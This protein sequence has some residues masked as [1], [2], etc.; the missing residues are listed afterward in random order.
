MKRSVSWSEIQTLDCTAKHAFRYT[1]Q[2]TGGTA[3]R[4]KVQASKLRAG[5]AWGRAVAALLSSPEELRPARYAHALDALRAELDDQAREAGADYNPDERDTLDAHLGDLLWHYACLAEPL[6]LFSAE[7]ELRLPVPSRNGGRASTVYEFEGYVDG[8]VSDEHGV[9]IYE[10]KLRD[11]L[12][13][14]E[15]VVESRQTRFYAWAAQ[16]LLD[17]PVAGVIVDERRNDVPRPARWVKGRKKGEGMVPSHAVDQLTTADLYIEACAEAGVEP[18]DATVEAFRARK[19]QERHKVFYTQEELAE[20]GEELVAA[21]QLIAMLDTGR[22]RPF[23]NPSVLR[24]GMCAFR[25]AVCRTPHD[26]ELIDIDYE[27][28]AP[29]RARGLELVA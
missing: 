15:Q 11:S 18:I 16:R 5:R 26:A 22:M 14:Y 9:W 7:L 8:L 1:G 23:R 10:A 2:L 20:A 17:R 6:R 19:W 3:L 27:R 21:S 28:V 24:C 29:K 13:S 25:G 12:S 4:R